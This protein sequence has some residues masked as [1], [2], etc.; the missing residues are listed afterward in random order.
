VQCLT[1]PTVAA[2]LLLPI[3]AFSSPSAAPPSP[4]PIPAEGKYFLRVFGHKVYPEEVQ[5]AHQLWLPLKQCVV[6][7]WQVSRFAWLKMDQLQSRWQREVLCLLVFGGSWSSQML[8]AAL[9]LQFSALHYCWRGC[10]HTKE[11]RDVC[12][13]VAVRG[14]V[15]THIVVGP[16]IPRC[17]YS[18]HCVFT[19]PT[20]AG[21]N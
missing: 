15:S 4:L 16:G 10:R 19:L 5:S 12:R 1:F 13:W 2:E 8:A 18:L 3:W 20:Q 11:E 17:L 14:S 7:T 21:G 6:L 9:F